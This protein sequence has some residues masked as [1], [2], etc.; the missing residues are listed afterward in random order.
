MPS[1]ARRAFLRG[2][3]PPT[4]PWQQFCQRLRAV[5]T[6]VVHV[7]AADGGAQTLPGHQAWLS[8]RHP[9]DVH[10]ARSLCAEYGVVLALDHGAPPNLPPARPVLWVDPGAGMRT[11]ERLQADGCAWFAQSGC[12]M[13]QLA[14]AGLPGF[15]RLPAHW[16]LS[17]WL[18]DRQWCN[19]ETGATARSGITHAAVLLADGSR[20]VLGPFGER[21]Q[22]P[23]TSDAQRRLVS[24]LFTLAASAPAQHCLAAAQW[25]ARYRLDALRP[26]KGADVNLAQL[27]CG[28]GGNLAW[29]EWLVFD[30]R[31]LGQ[32]G[33]DLTR[34]HGG[35]DMQTRQAAQTL[36]AQ[37][38]ALFDPQ[39]LFGTTHT[40]YTTPPD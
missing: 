1:A 22:T 6:G 17:A 8:P 29:V 38:K 24:G 9:A 25:P 19:W 18:S 3:R 39:G 23:L 15:A 35:R 16:S 5:V 20:A 11:C 7:Q 27:L 33:A 13:G 40:L 26:G 32:S 36:D 21:Q 12:L 37:V 34:W 10:R 31:L 4:P 14:A 28:H 2:R 30:E